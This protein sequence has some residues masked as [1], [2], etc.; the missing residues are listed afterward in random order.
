MSGFSVDLCDQCCLFSDDQNIQKGNRIDL[1][2]F[3]SEAD[4]RP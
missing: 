1:L 2:S 3:H 4:G